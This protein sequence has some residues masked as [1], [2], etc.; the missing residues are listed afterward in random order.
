[1]SGAPTPPQEEQPSGAYAAYVPH[2]LEYSAEFEDE[3]MRV[4][5]DPP[6]SDHAIRI[7]PDDSNEV[8]VEGVS[9][10]ASA[11]SLQSLPAIAEDELPLPL[12]DPRRIF[13]SHV[14]GV[15]LTHPGG[16][17]EGG[18]GLDPD[19]DTFPEDFLANNAS[20]TNATSP[21]AAV[22]K[23]IDVAKEVLHD[24]MRKRQDA[25][26]H[27]ERIERELKKMQE[28]HAMEMNVHRKM[29]EARR[30]KKEAKEQRRLGK[31]AGE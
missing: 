29:A 9:V 1:M 26:N 4:V 14:P 27:N 25:I 8:A 16:Y 31:D 6:P 30:A 17:L 15:R 3:V 20:A 13:A 24:R 19:M 18:P 7:I 21:R 28:E 12:N 11:I 23:D 22:R 2:D 10:K 5:L